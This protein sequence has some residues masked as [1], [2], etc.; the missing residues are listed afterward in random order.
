MHPK[1]K[2]LQQELHQELINILNYWMHF[3]PDEVNGGFYGSILHN[4]KIKA[5]APKGVVINARILW[6][7]SAAYQLLHNEKY[8]ALAQRAYNYIKQY[9]IDTEYGGVY[10]SVDASGNIKESRKQIYGLAF[11]IYGLSEY[12]AASKNEA[13]LQ[14]AKE[15]YA[16]IETYSFD[17]GYKGYTEACTREWQPLH[18]LRLSAK[19]ANE[20]KTMNTHLHIIEAYAS[21]YKLWPDEMLKHKIEELLFLFDQYFINHHTGHLRLFFD[22]QWN[23]KPGVISYGHDIE[24]A[25]LL[26]QCAEI[27][28]HDCWIKKY[29]EHAITI[30]NAATKGL[31]NDGGLWYEYNLTKQELVKEKHWWPQAEAIVGFYNAYQISNDESYLDKALRSWV[32]IKN[33]L[34]DKENGE[35][36]WG[37]TEN[38]SV[39]KNYDK[40]GFWKC[41]YHNSRAC[42]EILKRNED[43]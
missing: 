5:D 11:C 12:Y 42:L 38:N 2:I 29:K 17:A 15:L 22:E 8:L 3:T 13:A 26:L 39:M 16:C 40:A 37:I 23:E 43:L 18:D 10:W 25:W 27:V 21:L 1:V 19:D 28:Q 32:F 33:H 7:F 36:F 9:F 20:K 14:Y 4:N 34:L 6:T 24:A 30:T 41:P 31:D 35:W